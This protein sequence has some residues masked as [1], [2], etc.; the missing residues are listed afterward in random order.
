MPRVAPDTADVF[1]RRR[2]QE[3]QA[4]EVETGLGGDTALVQR[5]AVG[6]EDREDDPAE[7][8]TKA[9]CT[10]GVGLLAL[11]VTS[12]AGA[13]PPRLVQSI[14]A[15]ASGNVPAAVIRLAG[16]PAKPSASRIR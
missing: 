7:V 11:T 13:S 12:P 4:D 3:V 16:R 15:N 10:L 9:G 14:L 5:R 6:V 1:G 8:L 2:V